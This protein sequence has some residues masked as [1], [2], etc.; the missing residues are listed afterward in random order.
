[1]VKNEK[2]IKMK[3]K[4][5]K[6]NIF[7]ILLIVIAFFAGFLCAYFLL[8]EKPRLEE[9]VFVTQIID[10]DTITVEGGARIRLLGI[11]APEKGKEFYEESK[12]FLEDK[13][14]HKNINLEKDVTDKDRYDR[15]LRYIWLDDSLINAEIVRAG[16]AIAKYYGDDT[17]YQQL[18]ANAEQQAMTEKIGVWS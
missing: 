6:H 2:S 16:L 13:I 12:N 5:D 4:L 8:Q 11:D 3:R 14:L 1:M 17:K 10:G 9:E 18:I 15:F 7:S